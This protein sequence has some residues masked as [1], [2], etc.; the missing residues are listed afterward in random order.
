MPHGM[1]MAEKIMARAS[2][3]N[4]VL[5]GEYVTARIDAAMMPDAFRLI[6]NILAKA[7][8]AEA[9]FRIW[10]KER[11]VVFTDHQS[12]A[13]EL[14]QAEWVQECRSLA[15]SLGVKHFYD[16][17]PGISHQVMMEKGHVAPGELV[18]VADS[19]TV[20]YGALNAASTGIGASEMAYAIAT[21]E[22]WFRVPE[23]VRF[24]IT[25]Q[26]AQHVYSKDVLLYVA[27]AWGTEVAQYKAVEWCGTA[28]SAMS[29]DARATIANMSVEIGAKFGLFEADEK[30]LEF[31]RPRVQDRGY[32]PVRADVDAPVEAWHRIDGS[33]LAPQVALPHSVGNVVDVSQAAGQPI[34]QAVI[35]SCC[36][37]RI[38]DLQIAA[39]V[40]K[41]HKVAPG[42]RL[43]I[44]PASWALYQ[45]AMSL[46]LLAEL[47]QAGAMI[48][49]PACGFCTGYQGVLAPGE[50][51]IAATPRNF[52]GRMGS[53]A[54]NIYLA[55]PAT[56]AAS[57]IAGRITDP[58]ELN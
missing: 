12:P 44:A 27:G 6:R 14:G 5:P 11:F 16:V 40:L 53:N 31:V 50:H 15:K 52:K 26:L 34:D 42:V 23:T 46:G 43:Y 39:R 38:E 36:N 57:A 33:S 1:T 54:A 13:M 7:G 21:G 29:L 56:V 47:M 55:S 51:C 18:V 25:G 8:I 48:G 17:F 35:G 45:E 24:E 37:G 19:H 20:T 32:E 9:D 30:T 10:N 41:G 3:R 2:G 4:Q 49:N 22:L 28:V 58:R